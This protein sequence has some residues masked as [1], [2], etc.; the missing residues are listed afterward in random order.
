MRQLLDSH[1]HTCHVED[2]CWLSSCLGHPTWLRVWAANYS[3]SSIEDVHWFLRHGSSESVSL[4]DILALDFCL[5]TA[6]AYS[7]GV[8]GQEYQPRLYDYDVCIYLAL[9]EYWMGKWGWDGSV[10]RTV[11]GQGPALIY[12]GSC[13]C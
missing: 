4:L 8:D 5:G 9:L 2:V 1:A 11:L 6:T 13:F 7:F 3:P 12:V 10:S